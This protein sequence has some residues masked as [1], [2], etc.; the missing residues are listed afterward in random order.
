MSTSPKYK[1]EVVEGSV[2]VN[3]VTP[4]SIGKD[5]AIFEVDCRQ[6][7]TEIDGFTDNGVSID[8]TDETLHRKHDPDNKLPGTIVRIALPGVWYFTTTG[9]RYSHTL[10][11]VRVP[12]GD[13]RQKKIDAGT[14][15]SWHREIHYGTC[16]ACKKPRGYA[17]EEGSSV[18][19]TG[20]IC[21][22]CGAVEAGGLGQEKA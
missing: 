17:L 5:F 12:E 8:V 9:G 18:F 11:F 20:D 15:P 16:P 2:Q 1:I 19:E 21:A 14:W 6:K 10:S 4:L 22:D 7:Y 13:T 3:S